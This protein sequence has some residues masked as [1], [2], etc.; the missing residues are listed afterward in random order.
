MIFTPRLIYIHMPKTGGMWVAHVLRN[1][2]NGHKVPGVQRHGR[3]EDVPPELLDGR[4]LIGSVRDPWSWY[5]SLW[6]HLGNGSDGPHLRRALGS[7]AEDFPAFIRGATDA[8]VWTA[9]REDVR[10]GW[11]WP[12]P[13]N[14]GLYTA[15]LRHMYGDPISLD[16]LVDTAQ[17]HAGLSALLGVTVNP[18]TFPPKN[19][20]QDRPGTAV[21]DPRG[22][23]SPREIELVRKADGNAAEMLGFDGP[24][25][26]LAEP[27]SALRP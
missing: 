1:I 21:D 3:R 6:Q 16:V 7:G 5:A 22:L 25:S 9:V 8:T 20:R 2:A 12:H 4:T 18:M 13:M 11:P 14:R 15:L 17:L 19:T 24:F 10:G 23:F 27:T 26:R